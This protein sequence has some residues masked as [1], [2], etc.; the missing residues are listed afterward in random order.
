MLDTEPMNGT[1]MSF[2]CLTFSFHLLFILISS[3]LLYRELSVSFTADLRIA[4]DAGVLSSEIFK[5][6]FLLFKGQH[7]VSFFFD[8]F[9]WHI[10]SY[11]IT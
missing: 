11:A 9:L 8:I 2:N 1:G 5:R 10:A 7:C 3:V 4:V 6:I